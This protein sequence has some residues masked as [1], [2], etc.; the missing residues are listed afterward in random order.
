[1]HK[2]MT[3]DNHDGAAFCQKPVFCR[4]NLTFAT[5]LN[6]SLVQNGRFFS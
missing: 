5:H 2:I 3:L 4:Y 1:M 6:R